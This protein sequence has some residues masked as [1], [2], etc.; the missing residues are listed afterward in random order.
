MNVVIYFKNGNTAH[1]SYVED[2]G[3]DSRNIF[4]TFFGE[5][6]QERKRAIFYKD[7]I[8][9]IARTEGLEK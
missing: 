8:A 5:W 2:Y 3:S 4:F 7:S 9:G 1:F 6:P